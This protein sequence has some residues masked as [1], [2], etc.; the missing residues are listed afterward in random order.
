VVKST[1]R[2]PEA[3]ERHIR[4]ARWDVAEYDRLLSYMDDLEGGGNWWENTIG[5]G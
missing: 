3:V 1:E 4:N 2:P 5:S